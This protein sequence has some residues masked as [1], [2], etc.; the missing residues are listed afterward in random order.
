MIATIIIQLQF[1]VIMDQ[2]IPSYMSIEKLDGDAIRERITSLVKEVKKEYKAYQEEF[3]EFNFQLAHEMNARWTIEVKRGKGKESPKKRLERMKSMAR[4]YRL[5]VI[6][7]L[8]EK[9]YDKFWKLRSD[10][11]LITSFYHMSAIN[12]SPI[13]N[14][15]WKPRNQKYNPIVLRMN[16]PR[17]PKKKKFKKSDITYDLMEA[18]SRML[19]PL[20]DWV[21]KTASKISKLKSVTKKQTI[22]VKRNRFRETFVARESLTVLCQAVSPRQPTKSI[23]Q[24]NNNISL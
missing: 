23:S 1:N 15:D 7:R 21:D 10:I 5:E 13:L 16:G 11:S 14:M 20:E 19:K 18:I 24:E 6:S 9:W 12:I 4:K 17:K 2:A 3:K 8:T 22:Q